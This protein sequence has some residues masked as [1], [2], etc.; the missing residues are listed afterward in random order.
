MSKAGGGG[1]LTPDDYTGFEWRILCLYGDVVSDM[2]TIQ[3]WSKSA[4]HKESARDVEALRHLKGA[5]GRLRARD[6]R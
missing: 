2:G 4:L 5:F 6:Q 1:G 3:P